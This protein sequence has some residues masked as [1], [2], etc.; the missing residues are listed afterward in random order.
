MIQLPNNFKDQY[1]ESDWSDLKACNAYY[2][3]KTLA[4]KAAWDFLDALP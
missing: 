3:S 4:E 2:K 1:N